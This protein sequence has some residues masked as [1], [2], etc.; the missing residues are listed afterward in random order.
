MVLHQLTIFHH[1]DNLYASPLY[2]FLSNDL[3]QE[4]ANWPYTLL[5]ASNFRAINN[6]HAVSLLVNGEL[7]QLNERTRLL[8]LVTPWI[9]TTTGTEDDFTSAQQQTLSRY[10]FDHREIQELF[11]RKTAYKS[12][13][14]LNP[15]EWRKFNNRYLSVIPHTSIFARWFFAQDEAMVGQFLDTIPVEQISRKEILSL[16]RKLLGTQATCQQ[17]SLDRDWQPSLTHLKQLAQ[18]TKVDQ[19]VAGELAVLK[20]EKTGI[21]YL[22]R[23]FQA[24]VRTPQAGE[25]RKN[26]I[27]QLLRQGMTPI[28]VAWETPGQT[29]HEQTVETS[30]YWGQVIV[31][32]ETE[33][34]KVAS[35]LDRLLPN[36]RVNTPRYDNLLP[37]NRNDSQVVL[38][39]I[40]PT[41]NPLHHLANMGVISICQDSGLVTLIV[42]KETRFAVTFSPNNL[43]E[44]STLRRF[45][46][47]AQSM[48][49]AHLDPKALTR[50]EGEERIRNSVMK[51][52]N[53]TAKV[54]GLP[55]LTANESADSLPV[56][57]VVDTKAT[58]LY[59][60][61]LKIVER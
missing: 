4:H 29:T 28:L 49:T 20:E 40:L 35:Q 5:A 15:E 10:F 54:R 8:I 52:W 14:H 17:Q 22:D 11:W 38:P 47:I 25:T 36:Q 57:T 44:N 6:N 18:K 33:S 9:K 12:V 21:I 48:L 19:A 34:L 24:R 30:P 42:D 46:N 3:P 31:L 13:L 26:A 61:P 37:S 2:E 56:L 39:R 58:K 60:S 55:P 59:L 51:T 45:C 23:Q 16:V 43:P 32:D 7:D 50:E 27:A 41:D 53:S 1:I